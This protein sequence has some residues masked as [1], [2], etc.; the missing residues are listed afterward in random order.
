VTKAWYSKAF[1]LTVQDASAVINTV[2]SGALE[3]ITRKALPACGAADQLRERDRVERRTAL[4][5]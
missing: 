1:P 3:E 5:V 4:G 2:R